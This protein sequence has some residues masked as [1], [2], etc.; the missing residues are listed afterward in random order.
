MGHDPRK[1]GP[2][3]PSSEMPPLPPAGPGPELPE[4]FG[5][6]TYVKRLVTRPGDRLLV[7]VGPGPWLTDQQ[8]Y[9]IYRAFRD[10]LEIP[11]DVRILVMER[12]H[13]VQILHPGDQ[14]PEGWTEVDIKEP[15][16]QRG[17]TTEG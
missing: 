10:L 2:P 8:H 17:K 6:I 5:R 1:A 15:D 11:N 7:F 3:P 4:A 9:E 13:E 16:G 14:I 12:I